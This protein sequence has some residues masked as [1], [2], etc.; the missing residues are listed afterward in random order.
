MDGSPLVL[1]SCVCLYVG[2]RPCC[3]PEAERG[4][5]GE[6]NHLNKEDKTKNNY[7]LLHAVHFHSF[8]K[9][10]SNNTHPANL[11]LFPAKIHR[12]R[13]AYCT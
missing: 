3:W 12:K 11:N 1:E 4:E 13:R 9:S 5:G 6:D 7:H 2:L 10:E 8:P